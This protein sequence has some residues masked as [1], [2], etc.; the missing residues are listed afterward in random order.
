M[1]R[2]EDIFNHKNIDYI[3]L[4]SDLFLS[5]N[6]DALELLP[7]EIWLMMFEDLQLKEVIS[8]SK[9][10]AVFSSLTQ[11]R[12]DREKAAAIIQR[13]WK[14]AKFQRKE[15]FEGIYNGNTY[16][17]CVYCDK[18]TVLPC[19]VISANFEAPDR[20][21]FSDSYC[22]RCFVR[23]LYTFSISP[24]YGDFFQKIRTRRWGCL[25]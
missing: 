7:A 9:T 23:G 12:R 13:N 4:F 14:K 6:M 11:T 16:S 20:H 15:L 19:A 5:K 24:I 22:R 10:C 1:T 17:S 21:I 3:F 25:E 2:F 18:N 8:A